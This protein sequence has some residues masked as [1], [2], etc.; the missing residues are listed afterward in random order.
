MKRVHLE[1]SE[2][3]TALGSE[4]PNAHG[5]EESEHADHEVDGAEDHSDQS[6]R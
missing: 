5:D 1:D 4:E 2:Q 3:Q 6:I